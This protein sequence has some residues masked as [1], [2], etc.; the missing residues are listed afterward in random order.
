MRFFYSLFF[1]G[2]NALFSQDIIS[3][4]KISGTIVFDGK[5]DDT[6]WKEASVFP[7][8]VHYPSY[9]AVPCEL[10]E[11]MVGY[12]QEYLWV[13]ARLYSKDPANITSTSKKRDEESRNSDQ[14]GIILDT[15]DDNENALAFFTMP[16]GA[17]IDYTVSNDGE[18]G[19]GGG[20]GSINRSWNT[21][22]DVETTTR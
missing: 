20:M 13:G 19:G 21:F 22:W 17:R 7:L 16:S 1:S 9:G 10:S 18:G 3:I 11:V 8:M 4:K 2:T 15:Y 6:A 12:D 14:F 5:P